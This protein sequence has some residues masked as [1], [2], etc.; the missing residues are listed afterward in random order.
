MLIKSPTIIQYNRPPVVK[1]PP[2]FPRVIN[3]IEK[4][5][6]DLFS[7]TL[8]KTLI[9]LTKEMVNQVKKNK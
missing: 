4:K 9:D 3:P 5:A 8:N 2:R 6:K 7:F 1:D